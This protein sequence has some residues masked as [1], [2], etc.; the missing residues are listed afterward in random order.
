MDRSILFLT[1]SLLCFYLI[2]D[3]FVGK[4]KITGVLEGI[5]TGTG[6]TAAP[7]PLPDPEPF[8]PDKAAPDTGGATFTAIVERKLKAAELLDPNKH[9]NAGV[10]T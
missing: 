4:K 8:D 7:A 3:E 10:F 5:G 2:L 6:E 9:H 1:L